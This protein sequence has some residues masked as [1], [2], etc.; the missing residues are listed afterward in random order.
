LVVATAS[1]RLVESSNAGNELHSTPDN[2]ASDFEVLARV[3][4]LFQKM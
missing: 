3:G 1:A 2:R 4:D